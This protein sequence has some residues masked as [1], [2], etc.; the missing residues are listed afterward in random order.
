MIVASIDI[1]DGRAVQLVGGAR[2]VL[3]AGDPIALGERF[4]LVG[5]IAVIDLDAAMGCGENRRIVRK[6]VRRFP[7]RVGGGIR[8]R[9]SAL[10]WLDAGA[11]QVILG[12]AARTEL[13][14]S[15]PR[16]RVIVALDAIHGEV[17]THG[18]RT[19]TGRA[20]LDR[21]DELSEVAGSFLFTLIEREGRTQGTD[22]E[23]A[24]LLIER[25]GAARVTIAGG[26]TTAE[27]IAALD[28]LGADAQV[29]MALYTGRLDLADAVAAVLH[30]DRA[31]GLWPTVICDES[32]T[33]LGLAYSDAASLRR[34][35]ATRRGVYHSRTR[36]LWEK[37]A[38]SGNT[39]ALRRVDVDCDRDTLRF[40]V[41]QEGAGFCHRGHDTCWGL[42]QGV[43]GL[44]R[45]ILD[46]RDHPAAGSLTNALLS[47]PG[48]LARKL[49]EE[50]AELACARGPDAVTHEVADIL[51]FSLVAMTRGGSR[52][53]DVARELDRRARR[54]TRRF[55]APPATPGPEEDG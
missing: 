20:V 51:Y 21:I 30:S 27:E 13:I 3:D 52:L 1:R 2:P 24:R 45:R 14:A 44:V 43:G 28:R 18:W 42:Q 17:V 36:G 5:P 37:G 29:G 23:A 16:R 41:R 26:V 33:A 4:S 19:R 54:V 11:Q 9:R 47:D 46:R 35:I 53:D 8:S 34:A 7:C 32:Q 6:L 12:T 38:T 10:D 55:A 25:A 50:A 40:T 49:V 31:D 48:L 15:L 39:Q 22:L